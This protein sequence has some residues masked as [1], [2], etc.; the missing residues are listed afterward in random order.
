MFSSPHPEVS[1]NFIKQ[2]GGTPLG[3]DLGYEYDEVM[4]SKAFFL[5]TNC[6]LSINVGYVD[7]PS[8]VLLSSVRLTIRA[9]FSALPEASGTFCSSTFLIP[10]IRSVAFI[11][12][13]NPSVPGR[14]LF[15][16]RDVKNTPHMLPKGRVCGY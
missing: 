14:A 2:S 8:T 9:I 13:P 16:S 11:Y 7:H 12:S 1:A 4:R 10:L 3:Y 5:V 6:S 15:G